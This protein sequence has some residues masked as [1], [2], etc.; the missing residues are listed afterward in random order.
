M[1]I[2]QQNKIIR[3]IIIPRNDFFENKRTVELQWLDHLWN[4]ENTFETWV[5][6]VSRDSFSIFGGGRVVR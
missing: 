6:Q 5:V 2:D 1:K 3:T 4:H